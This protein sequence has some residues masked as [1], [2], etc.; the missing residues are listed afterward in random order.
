M[1]ISC[2]DCQIVGVGVSEPHSSE[3]NWEFSGAY[4]LYCVPTSIHI[5]SINMR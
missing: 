2:D 5:V 1:D 4:L 3:L